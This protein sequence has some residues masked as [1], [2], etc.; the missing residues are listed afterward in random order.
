MALG[1]FALHFSGATG[2]AACVMMIPRGI[3]SEQSKEKG[4]KISARNNPSF[5]Y[6]QIWASYL[7]SVPSFL[8]GRRKRKRK[9]KAGLHARLRTR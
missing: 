7:L 9:A 8:E 6:T 3:Q 1:I 4:S 5:S 2:C